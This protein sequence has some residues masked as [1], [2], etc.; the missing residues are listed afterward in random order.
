MKKILM[1]VNV[2]K[3]FLS[4][5]LPIADKAQKNNIDMHVFTEFTEIH[6]LE[7]FPNFKFK[8]SKI[9][10]QNKSLASLLVEFLQH[11]LR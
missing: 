8:K 9:S 4:H 1:Y 10:R 2:D 7:D 6:K 11:S 5:R 3:F